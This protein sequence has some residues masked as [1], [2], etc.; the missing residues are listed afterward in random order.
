VHDHLVEPRQRRLQSL[1]DPPGQI[2]A[3]RIL[4]PVDVVEV[5]VVE[6]V[7]KR[8]EGRFDVGEVHHPA[9][10]GVHGAFHVQFDSEGMAMQPRTLVTLG[11]V[12]QAVGGFEGEDFE[13][14]HPAILVEREVPTGF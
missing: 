9:G 1:E 11:H 4:Q 3:G 10:V 8:R 13:N 7:V 5:V 2:L 14:V 6:L 12:R